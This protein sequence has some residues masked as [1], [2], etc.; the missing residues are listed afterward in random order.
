MEL[1]GRT[2]RPHNRSDCLIHPRLFPNRL[3]ILARDDPPLKVVGR[4]RLLKDRVPVPES[5]GKVAPRRPDTDNPENRFDEK[6]VVRPRAARIL[7]FSRKKR[8]DPLPLI[9][10]QYTT[11]QGHLLLETLKQISADLRT[12]NRA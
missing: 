3:A 2:H 6:S 12:P 1:E 9:I 11:V 4:R 7:D 5:L 10:A 8:R